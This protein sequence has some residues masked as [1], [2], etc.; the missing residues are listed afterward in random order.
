[1]TQQKELF[2][3]QNILAKLHDNLPLSDRLGIFHQVIRQDFPFID[4]ISIF[5][6]DEKTNVLKTYTQSTIG[7][8]PLA[9]YEI[10]LSG[11]PVVKR[12]H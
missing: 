3:H 7:S 12:D 4:R 6:L 5:L 9:T 1:M 11:S 8:N 10:P 2:S